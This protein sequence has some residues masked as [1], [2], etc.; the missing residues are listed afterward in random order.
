[1]SY[2]YGQTK[3]A[4]ERAARAAADRYRALKRQA[5]YRRMWELNLQDPQKVWA[6]ADALA[7][8]LRHMKP[9]DEHLGPIRL[10]AAAAEADRG[11]WTR[12]AA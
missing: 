1:M 5:H 8:Y 7:L 2:V 6:E 9:E 10:E 11:G 4:R 12:R 3:G